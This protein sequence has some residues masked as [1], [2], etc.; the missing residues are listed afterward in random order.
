[1]NRTISQVLICL[2]ASGSAII[3][4]GKPLCSQENKQVVSPETAVRLRETVTHLSESI[5][6]RNLTKRANLGETVRYLQSTLESLSY[7][8]DRHAFT[9]SEVECVNLIADLVGHATPKEIV[10]VGAHYDS[11][12]GSPGANDNGSGVAAL[13]EIARQLRGKN[14]AK[15]VRFVLFANEEPPYFQRDGQMGSWVYARACRMRGDDIKIV[16]SLETMGYFTDEPQSQKYP[17]LLSAMYP[18][19]GNF[20][21]FISDVP[22]RKH[23]SSTVTIFKK[24]C[25]VD[26]QLGAFPRDLQGVGWSDHWSF[27]Q[28]GFPGIMITDTALFRYPHYHLA[29]DTPDKLEYNRFAEVVDGLAKTAV[30]LANTDFKNDVANKNRT[31]PSD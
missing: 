25:Q 3:G 15:T 29:S 4:V 9:V 8:V 30:E 12:Q 16:L 18:S 28:E 5:G 10:L 17:A 14:G 20:I 2:A 19:T 21:G 24:H 23:L 7:T 11:V 13:L 6:E 1:M 31:K 26:A 27:W 22:S